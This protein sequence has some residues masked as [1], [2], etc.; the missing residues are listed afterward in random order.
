M[1]H[2]ELQLL[3]L[4]ALQV[5]KFEHLKI[6]FLVSAENFEQLI[7]IIDL[8]GCLNLGKVFS[9]LLN[10]FHLLGNKLDFPLEIRSSTSRILR[11]NYNK[12][13]F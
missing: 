11:E 10:F 1:S 2:L 9:I 8:G 13:L 5:D 3:N 12:C 6:L 4:I 7:K